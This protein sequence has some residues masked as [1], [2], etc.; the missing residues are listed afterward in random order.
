MKINFNSKFL[1]EC[2]CR[3]LK[4]DKNE[5]QDSDISK[6]KY[7]HTM[8]QGGYIAFSSAAV[9]DYIYFDEMGDETTNLYDLWDTDLNLN[10]AVIIKRRR[11]GFYLEKN[12]NIQNRLEKNDVEMKKFQKSI[13]S[14]NP[15]IPDL[16][17]EQ[18][19]D[20]SFKEIDTYYKEIYQFLKTDY[21]DLKFLSGLKAF[22]M[23]DVE[24]EVIES[25]EFLM[26]MP[27]LKILEL[28]GYYTIESDRGF[29]E[30]K[31]LNQLCVWES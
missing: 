8:G 10:E 30:L 19:Q 18:I 20:M 12:N 11:K 2:V 4:I 7:L 25:L 9:P 3:F 17:S 21:E 13:I 27:N 29:R 23:T 22:R 26:Y 15:D 31:K 16:S 1:S 24:N 6:I 28:G 14:Y 5:L